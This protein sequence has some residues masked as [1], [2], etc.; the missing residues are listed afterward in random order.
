MG[1]KSIH[2]SGH[3]RDTAIRLGS[4]AN[5]DARGIKFQ[6][7]SCIQILVIEP[8]KNRLTQVRALWLVK[9]GGRGKPR[10]KDETSLS[11]C[12]NDTEFARGPPPPPAA[13]LN[14]SV[15]P[16]DA[17]P[18]LNL[19]LDSSLVAPPM[20]YRGNHPPSSLPS[21]YLATRKQYH[22]SYPPHI[23]WPPIMNG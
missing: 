18:P 21:I 2:V 1:G 19:R 12:L 20:T 5:I 8:F 15:A 10:G 16:R 23:R 11:H 22:K 6:N 9:E 17:P 4:D 7:L 14:H 3:C 13:V